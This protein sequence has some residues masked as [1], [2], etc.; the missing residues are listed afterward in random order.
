M[1]LQVPDPLARFFLWFFGMEFPGIN[2]DKLAGLARASSDLARGVEGSEREFAGAVQRILDGVEG[3]SKRAFAQKA[4]DIL[5]V[6]QNAG[7]FTRGVG[8]QHQFAAG[9]VFATKVATLTTVALLMLELAY[10]ISMFPISP[11]PWVNFWAK[12]PLVRG[13]LRAFLQGV[14][15]RFATL[16]RVAFAEALQELL[17]ALAGE[18]AALGRYGK[19]VDGR[20]VMTSAAVGGAFGGMMGTAMPL[21][22]AAGA[23]AARRTGIDR[24]LE[25]ASTNNAARTVVTGATDLGQRGVS[26]VVEASIETALSVAMGGGPANFGPTVV[27]SM[28]TDATFD[29][30]AALKDRTSRALGRGRPDSERPAEED[31]TPTP[32]RP[33]GAPVTG[34]PTDTDTDSGPPTGSDTSAG[35]GAVA[36]AGVAAAPGNAAPR[37]HDGVSGPPPVVEGVPRPIGG[38]AGFGESGGAG[39]SGVGGAGGEGVPSPAV[40]AGTATPV[41]VPADTNIGVGAPSGSILGDSVD[42]VTDAPV[43]EGAAAAPVSGPPPA[44]GNESPSPPTTGASWAGTVDGSATTATPTGA[45]PVTPGGS[46]PVTPGG[47]TP[48]TGGQSTPVTGGQ[49]TT[50]PTSTPRP[51]TVPSPS[52][53]TLPPTAGAAP[54]TAAPVTANTPPTVTPT[55]ASVP[56]AA[57]PGN[58]VVDNDGLLP[59]SAQPPVEQAAPAEP[60]IVEL[61]SPALRE[62][63]PEAL[64]AALSQTSTPAPTVVLGP[65]TNA[66]LSPE[67]AGSATDDV[68]TDGP[69][70]VPVDLP[71]PAGVMPVAV[72]WRP[73]PETAGKAGRTPHDRSG[74]SAADPELPPQEVSLPG[75][76]LVT[77]SVSENPMAVPIDPSETVATPQVTTTGIAAATPPSTGTDR[78][79]PTGTDQQPSAPRQGVPAQPRP[80]PPANNATPP[81]MAHPAPIDAED[82]LIRFMDQ[83]RPLQ[84]YARDADDDGPVVDL[85][86]MTASGNADRVWV[87][88]RVPGRVEPVTLGPNSAGSALLDPS[89][90]VSAAIRID[91]QQLTDAVLFGLE[92]SELWTRSLRNGDAEFVRRF[93]RAAV[94]HRITDAPMGASVSDFVQAMVPHSSR[95][96]S[97]AAD[98]RTELEPADAV[99]RSSAQRSMETNADREGVRAARSWAEYQVAIDHQRPVVTGRA[100]DTQR[101][102]LGLLDSFATML[103]AKFLEEGADAARAMSQRLAQ[104]YGTSRGF[105]LLPPPI[106]TFDVSGSQ[107]KDWV[108]K[109]TEHAGD[110]RDFARQEA[111]NPAEN[112]ELVLLAAPS[113]VLAADSAFSPGHAVVA[114]RLPNGKQTA[115]GFYPDEGL[116]GAQG[117]IKDDR[118][119]L[120]AR[121]ARVLGAYNISARQLSD[122]Y[123]FAARNSQEN[124]HLLSSNC[125]VFAT[126]LV[127]TALGRD[128][129]DPTVTTPDGLIATLS[130]DSTWTWSDGQRTSIPA[131]PARASREANLKQAREY[132]EL[133][134]ERTEGYSNALEWATFRIAVDHQRPLVTRQ[135]DARQAEQFALLDEFTTM[136]A[137]E[138]HA[139]GEVAAAALSRSLGSAHGTLRNPDPAGNA[140]IYELDETDAT[141]PRLLDVPPPVVAGPLATA[142]PISEDSPTWEFGEGTPAGEVIFDADLRDEVETRPDREADPG[143]PV[144][145]RVVSGER[146]EQL[147]AGVVPRRARAA[148]FDVV[149]VGDRSGFLPDVVVRSYEDAGLDVPTGGVVTRPDLDHVVG[150]V[151]YRYRRL[152]DSDGSVV[153]DFVVRVHLVAQD[154][155]AREQ[156]DVVKARAVDGVDAVFNGGYRIGDGQFNAGVEFVDDPADA[157]TTVALF[158]EDAPPSSQTSWSVNDNGETFAHEFGHYLGLFD[159]YTDAHS[160]GSDGNRV[161]RIFNDHSLASRVYA[162]G[163][164]MATVTSAENPGLRPRHLD[165]I[166]DTFAGA[167]GPDRGTTNPTPDPTSETDTDSTLDG[168]V[169]GAPA[170]NSVVNA[171]FSQLVRGHEAVTQ[172]NVR[173]KRNR[174]IAQRAP[175]AFVVNMMVSANGVHELQGVISSITQ[176]LP[177]G[178]HVAFV[179]GVNTMGRE[180]TRDLNRAVSAAGQIAANAPWP[181]AVV[182][183][184]VY[185][186]PKNSFPFGRA[187]NAVMGAPETAAAVSAFA[188]RGSYPYVAFQDFDTGA[189]T[190]A[191]GE[192]IFSRMVNLTGNHGYPLRPLMLSGGYRIGDADQLV[193]DTIRRLRDQENDPE[194]DQAKRN[195][196]RDARKRLAADK[197]GFVRQFTAAIQEDMATRDR[198]KAIH[199]LLPYGPEPNLF[200]DGL[201]IGS[202]PSVQFGDGGSEFSQLSVSLNKAYAGELLAEQRQLPNYEEMSSVERSAQIQVAGQNNQHPQRGVAY[203]VD[204]MGSAVPTDLSRLAAEFSMGKALPQDHAKLA[205]VLNRFFGHDGANTSDDAPLNARAAK[206]GTSLTEYAKA[207]S[208]IAGPY[209]DPAY[210]PAQASFYFPPA[211]AP[212]ASSSAPTA[213]AYGY[214]PITQALSG[215][216][217]NQLG[218]QPHNTLYPAISYAVPNTELHIG[219]PPSQKIYAA[220]QLA[221]SNTRNSIQQEFAHVAHYANGVPVRPDSVY[222]VLG[223]QLNLPADEVRRRALEAGRTI[224]PL[225]SALAELRRTKDY[226]NGHF[227][228]AALSAPRAQP[229]AYHPGAVIPGMAEADAEM[230]ATA[231]MGSDSEGEGSGSETSSNAS[232]QSAAERQQRA[233]AY[234]AVLTATAHALDITIEVHTPPQGAQRYGNKG[235]THRIDRYTTAD[236]RVVFDDH[237]SRQPPP[238]QPPPPPAGQRF[239]LPAPV[240]MGGVPAHAPPAGHFPYASS[241]QP[242]PSTGFAAPP[243]P[244]PYPAPLPQPGP[245][246]Q[247]Y[248]QPHPQ[249][250][251]YP[252]ADPSRGPYPPPGSFARDPR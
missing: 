190:V 26:G 149:H 123:D 122:A 210:H 248:P 68:V 164:I 216:Q 108:A 2:E 70:G 31:P 100:T 20:Q 147:R 107:P 116:F 250:Q 159:E 40:P 150:L 46:T 241:G 96:W 64:Q 168:P 146:I 152:V 153:H 29:A 127:G 183:H 239:R 251:P 88:V 19:G 112:I 242:G 103:T 58:A 198:Q 138:Y 195:K 109:F 117:A 145:G 158:G 177:Q 36:G 37:S 94:G 174:L 102:Q 21:I 44:V 60:E 175:L 212:V 93:A 126:R 185:H 131:G 114:I 180:V 170:T 27:S 233:N 32:V 124:Y 49:P 247:A 156:L 162:D 181:I 211:G 234:D 81:A 67:P 121:H 165:Q 132:L 59:E 3:N 196:A 249:R 252:P 76:P 215:K 214:P 226:R 205:S 105:T 119:Y 90:R 192:H 24:A 130:T 201:L 172:A 194:R 111:A 125:V 10:A 33:G 56:A 203:L 66:E 106:S 120:A 207:S 53:V 134:G 38:S 89:L 245:F 188:G 227:V 142:R 11:V 30:A 222:A 219:V 167:I 42:G 92:S 176:G 118:K 16:S 113:R 82:G 5:G 8:T 43:A 160:T 18:L 9:T 217:L 84:E 1:A 55:E 75:T 4:A 232:R 98:P 173:A 35:S 71:D 7:R 45:A 231:T 237:P 218:N 99:A 41:G 143:E 65:E 179:V 110:L 169:R 129:V 17:A 15:S 23:G 230:N 243:Y 221:L 200:V 161:A 137:A 74:G 184:A 85:V 139:N 51:A 69:G 133:V 6:L 73:A 187:R 151:G 204:Y 13:G 193:A 83:V 202:D 50:G 238:P 135:P 54:A 80:A 97:E 208:S 47:P 95:A 57:P 240:P 104:D 223:R 86:V 62:L 34:L 72:G 182:G 91:R 144:R 77:G 186:G 63:S 163:S 136:V 14:L 155:V 154:S 25:A 22:N 115:L 52:T 209:A 224:A 141:S 235:R 206:R 191:T 225:I 87:E 148:A 28:L 79:R 178:A 140:A 128:I 171:A 101:A 78:G 228:G 166:A 12:A 236:G 199:P 229:G 157:D 197:A 61:L 189:R 213:G 39:T 220:H 244:Q 48:V 246:P